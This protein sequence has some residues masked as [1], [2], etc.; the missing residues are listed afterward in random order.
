[1]SRILGFVTVFILITATAPVAGWAQ[2]PSE[3]VGFNGPPIDDY[4]AQEMFQI[5]QWS[6]TTAA[7]VVPNITGQYDMDAA[8]RSIR[9]GLDV[10]LPEH[11][12]RG[13]ARVAARRLGRCVT[14]T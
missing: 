7:F 5:P 11:G 13:V 8:F 3:L 2:Y 10:A 4:T 14:P 9:A 6:G 1:M 12:P